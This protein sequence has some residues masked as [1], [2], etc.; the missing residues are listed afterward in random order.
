MKAQHRSALAFTA[1]T[2]ILG[3]VAAGVCFSTAASADDGGTGDIG[4][5]VTVAPS[6]AN[7]TATPPPVESIAPPAPAEATTTPTATQPSSVA[8]PSATGAAKAQSKAQD[9][10]FGGVLY[11][12]GLTAKYIWNGNPLLSGASLQFTVRNVSK[13]TFD[14]TARFW[15]DTTVGGLIAETRGVHIAALK[16]GESRVVSVTMG[17]LGQWTVMH[18]H[19]TLTPPQSVDGKKLNQVTRDAYFF[20]PPLAVGSVGV[21]GLVGLGAVLTLKLGWLAK[22]ARLVGLAKVLP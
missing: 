11:V 18:A 16:P 3:G 9:Y 22:L 13:S 1:L 15:I 5:V 21:V 2:F 17:N 6:D 19:A 4:I 8:T 7:A 10:S 14:S 20:V 12:S